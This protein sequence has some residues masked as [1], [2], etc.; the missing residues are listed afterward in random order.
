MLGEWDGIANG[1]GSQFVSAV[2]VVPHYVRGPIPA[3]AHAGAVQC[4]NPN[5]FA[6]TA[7]PS[8]G[9]CLGGDTPLNCQFG[10]LGRY[11]SRGAADRNLGGITNVA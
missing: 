2:P 3:V 6:S 11:A 9:A 8:T 10:S 5:A 4:L 7:V 1:S